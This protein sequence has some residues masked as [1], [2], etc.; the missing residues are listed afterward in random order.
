MLSC[1][2]KLEAVLFTSVG[3]LACLRPLSVPI[4]WTERGRRQQKG[5]LSN[6][7]EACFKSTVTDA[8]FSLMPV[9]WAVMFPQNAEICSTQLP[10][11]QAFSGESS[12][13]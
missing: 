13:R 2:V 7:T 3:K 6:K 9:M 5:S 8:E 4:S 12:W 11:F 1:Q 10:Q